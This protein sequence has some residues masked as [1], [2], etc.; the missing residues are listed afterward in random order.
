MLRGA[1]WCCV[2][3]RGAA[4]CFVVLKNELVAFNQVCLKVNGYAIQVKH[5]WRSGRRERGER[6]HTSTIHENTHARR[7][8][9]VP[10]PLPP[11]STSTTL[12]AMA[13]STTSVIHW[14]TEDVC[15]WLTHFPDLRQ[16]IQV[17]KVCEFLLFLSLVS[18]LIL[19]QIS[20]SH[21]VFCPH[22]IHS[23]PFH[24]FHQRESYVY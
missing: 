19:L 9:C 13:T 12:Y 6:S 3:L 18:H 2:V 15:E 8:P 16:Y 17:F 1:A 21:H 22:C 4:S 24:P 11:S 10:L 5:E 23:I 7:L 20:S 14:T